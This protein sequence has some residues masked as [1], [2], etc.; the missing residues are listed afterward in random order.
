MTVPQEPKG[1]TVAGSAFLGAK[2]TDLVRDY[3]AAQQVAARDS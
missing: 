1:F 3:Y 2:P